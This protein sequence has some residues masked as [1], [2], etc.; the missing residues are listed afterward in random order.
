MQTTLR[1]LIQM[2]FCSTIAGLREGL[3]GKTEG[4]RVQKATMEA[5]AMIMV[6]VTCDQ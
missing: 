4:K 1:A 2:A 6:V 3:G 5:A